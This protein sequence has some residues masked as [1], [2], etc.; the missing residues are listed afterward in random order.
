MNKEKGKNKRKNGISKGKR[1]ERGGSEELKK[2]NTSTKNQNIWW[3][4]LTTDCIF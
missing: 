3:C 4:Y 1:K 2:K